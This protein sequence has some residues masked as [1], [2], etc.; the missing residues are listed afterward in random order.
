MGGWGRAVTRRLSFGIRTEVAE[1]C[2]AFFSCS[3]CPELTVVLSWAQ[4]RGREKNERRFLQ[5]VW[6]WVKG[7]M[8]CFRSRV[9]PNPL[10][11]WAGDAAGSSDT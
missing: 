2:I 11:E 8:P 6:E 4:D 7:P 5:T 9:H 3:L 1:R 10:R